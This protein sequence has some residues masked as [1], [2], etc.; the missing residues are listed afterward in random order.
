MHMHHKNAEYRYASPRTMAMMMKLNLTDAQKQQVKDLNTDYRN[1][2]KD[3]EKNENI[4]LKDYRAK[5]ASLEQERKS[6]FQDILTPEQK[7]KIA[8]AKKER[9]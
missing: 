8:Q 6:K 4:T 1:Q 2:L 3:L 7:N 5:K 9:E